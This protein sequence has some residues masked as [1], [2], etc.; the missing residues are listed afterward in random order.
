MVVLNIIGLTAVSIYVEKTS[1]GDAKD[2][3]Q[4]DEGDQ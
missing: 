3:E 2:G 1:H 4:G